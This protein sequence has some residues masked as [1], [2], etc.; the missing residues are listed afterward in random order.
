MQKS[1]FPVAKSRSQS[2]RGQIVRKIMLL[3]KY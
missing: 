2:V 3:I 1:E